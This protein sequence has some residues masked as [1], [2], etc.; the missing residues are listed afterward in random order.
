MMPLERGRNFDYMYSMRIENTEWEATKE[1]LDKIFELFKAFPSGDFLDVGAGDGRFAK[2]V[3]KLWKRPV[4]LVELKEEY[5]SERG[6]NLIIKECDLDNQ[7]LP[8][9]NEYFDYVT[10]METIEHL[11]N[12]WFCIKEIARVLKPNGLL[13]LTAPNLHRLRWRL[14]FFLR[15]NFREGIVKKYSTPQDHLHLFFLDEL[16]LLLSSNGFS[17]EYIYYAKPEFK[18]IPWAY[19]RTNFG[20]RP[21]W[22]NVA[23]YLKQNILGIIAQVISRVILGTWSPENRLFGISLII[24]ARK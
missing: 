21:K 20:S 13:L 10:F 12:P 1:V 5:I 16:R 3:A 4:H 24:V 14:N 7:Q 23:G 2:R 6:P 15:G 8:Y 18:R 17:E 19:Y 9:P 22:R 11:R